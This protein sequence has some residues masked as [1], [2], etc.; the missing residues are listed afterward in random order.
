MSIGANGFMIKLYHGRTYNTRT[1]FERATWRNDG[2][3]TDYT[4]IEE[5]LYE[6]RNGYFFLFCQGGF[7]TAYA[8]YKPTNR[9]RGN[10]I[11]IPLDIPQAAEWASKRVSTEEF[12]N[13]FLPGEQMM[14]HA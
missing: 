2:D 8:R 12:W 4:H 11:I 14:R 6:T 7:L 10:Q 9:S 13:I 1:A 3:F 5:T